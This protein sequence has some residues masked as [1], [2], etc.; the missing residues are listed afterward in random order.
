[1]S[2][3]KSTIELK[4]CVPA[5]EKNRGVQSG[6]ALVRNSVLTSKVQVDELSTQTQTAE[7]KYVNDYE[8]LA[9]TISLGSDNEIEQVLESILSSDDDI[10]ILVDDF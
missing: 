4:G 8:T 6:P 5:F 2:K 1:M 7:V 9:E 10:D 3:P